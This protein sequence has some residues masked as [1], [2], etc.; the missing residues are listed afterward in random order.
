MSRI[1][2]QPIIIPDKVEVKIEGNLIMVKGPK[3]ELKR[4]LPDKIKAEI[5]GGKI[6]FFPISQNDLA[7]KKVMALWGLSRALVANMVKGAKD[8]YE[9]KLEIEGVGYRAALQGNDLVLSLGFSH[10]VEFKSP[11]GIIFKVEK[12]TILVS[13][14]DKETVGQTAAAIR[15]LKKPEPYKGKGIRYQGEIIKIKAGKKAVSSEM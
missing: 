3:G 11:E 2:K 13:G 6:L 14:A 15:A 4:N 8:G 1:G 12:N 5:E 10:P 9:K 7:N